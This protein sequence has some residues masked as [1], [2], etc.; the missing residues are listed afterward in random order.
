MSESTT[1]EVEEEKLDRILQNQA[2]LREELD[3]ARAER[4]ELRQELDAVRA[5]RDELRSRLDT[6]EGDVQ[7][8][9]EADAEIRGRVTDVE[10][11]VEASEAVQDT[12]EALEFDTEAHE[13]RLNKITEWKKQEASPRLEELNEAVGELQ[14]EVTGVSADKLDEYT[15]IE[16]LATMSEDELEEHTGVN[17]QRA[18]TIFRNWLDWSRKVKGGRVKQ[19]SDN[20]IQLLEAERGEDLEHTQLTR[21]IERLAELSRGTIKIDEKNG[22]RRLV[23]SKDREFASVNHSDASVTKLSAGV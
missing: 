14:S 10:D 8:L 12:M 23:Q 17:E 20:L 22:M 3:E 7:E 11:S 15:P 4:D 18:V 16:K 13:N 21:A 19:T 1:V 9:R 5:E 2:E 6:V